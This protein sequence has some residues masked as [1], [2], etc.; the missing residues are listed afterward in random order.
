MTPNLHLLISWVS[1]VEFLKERRERTLVAIS[2]IAPDIDALGGFV[3]SFTGTTDYYS[4]YHHYLGHSLFSVII[5]STLAMFLAKTQKK[6]VWLLSFAII[7]IHFLCDVIGSRGPDGYQWPIYY[8]YPF[9]STFSLKWSGQWE[10]NAWQNILL[11]GILLSICG[12][13]AVTKRIT[14]VEVFSPKLDSTILNFLSKKIK[15]K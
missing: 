2:G 14:F 3:D 12:F 4:K 13:Y 10:L 6:I 8:L 11:L 1:S 15:G 5:L 7:H 9:N